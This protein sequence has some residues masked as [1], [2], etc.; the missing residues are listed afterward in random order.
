MN[1]VNAINTAACMTLLFY[2]LI[3]GH[4][5]RKVRHKLAVWGM[6][7]VIGLQAIDP[8][9]SWIPDIAWPAA[10]LTVALAV[11]V[12]LIRADLWDMLKGRMA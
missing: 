8:L 5:A 12:T 9:V 2:L 10:L 1:W 6:T 7:V 11:A 4:E 3:A